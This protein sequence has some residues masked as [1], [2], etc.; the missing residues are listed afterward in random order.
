MPT[1]SQD[2]SPSLVQFLSGA[3][4]V[5]SPEVEKGESDG[6]VHSPQEG[7]GDNYSN[8]NLL[9]QP[10]NPRLVKQILSN[11]HNFRAKS[12]VDI[13][14]VAKTETSW[15]PNAPDAEIVN[16]LSFLETATP[17]ASSDHTLLIFFVYL[18]YNEKAQYQR[19]ASISKAG[20]AK[21]TG[22]M[23][24]HDAAIQNMLGRPDYW[25]AFARWKD[26]SRGISKGY[27]FFCQ[28][29]RWLQKTRY[30]KL[31]HR[32]PYSV[33]LHHDN[34]TN[35][36]YYIISSARDEEYAMKI[37]DALSIPKHEKSYIGP[38]IEAAAS[39]FWI[40]AFMSGS[41]YLQSVDYLADVRGQLFSQIAEVNDYSK[42]SYSG[43]PSLHRNKDGRQKLQNITKNLHTISQTCD[44]G[45]AN[46]NMSIR[47]CEEMLEAYS[48]FSTEP[49]NP[50]ESWRQIHDSIQWV[51]KTWHCQK[52]WLI[53]YKAR[54]DTAMNFVYNLVTQQDNAVNL[55]I[56]HRAAEHSSSMNAI[57]ILTM[58]FLPG[59]FL[60]G[61]F[62]SGILNT[63]DSHGISNIFWPF[64]SI[65]LP[66]T[67]LTTAL[68]FW[69]RQLERSYRWGKKRMHRH[70]DIEKNI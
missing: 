24:L 29:P 14:K 2:R 65:L 57:T 11:G 10:W 38:T 31:R 3:T 21:L 40:H 49:T 52:N 26:I 60:A 28:H 70:N 20:L 61:I 66:L 30:D 25:S 63:N 67:L 44:S 9:L 18:E 53:S 6:G 36:S 33:Y 39:P 22:H 55:D 12:N 68:W 56:A 51:L 46:A 37:L 19:Q 58:V 8:A 50:P 45:I 16:Q 43:F 1:F 27:E 35:T 13:L 62:G 48:T 34:V 64:I 42:E 54:K 23:E 47:L 4:A 15:L 69:R 17:F 59:T 5:G 32:A 41:A 7:G